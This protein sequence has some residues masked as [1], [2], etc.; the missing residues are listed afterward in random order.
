MLVVFILPQT[1]KVFY[2]NSRMSYS[3]FTVWR[4]TPTK[5]FQMYDVLYTVFSILT[6]IKFK[7]M[8]N[9]NISTIKSLVSVEC[10]AI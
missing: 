10:K 3:N 4:L 2:Q 9:I 1:P 6:N 5:L 8:L 7:C